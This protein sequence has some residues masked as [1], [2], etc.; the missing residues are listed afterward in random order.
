MNLDDLNDE[1][2]LD[3][4]DLTLSSE[5]YDSIGGLVIQILDRLPEVGDEVLT[6]NGIR[7]KVVSFEKNRIERIHLFLPETNTSAEESDSEK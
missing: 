1:L 5:D 3:D 7:M 4:L 6:E 2:K